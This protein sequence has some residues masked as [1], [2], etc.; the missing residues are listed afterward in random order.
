MYLFLDRGE[1]REKE[2][3][4]NINVWLPLT[5]SPYEDLDCNPGMCPDWESNW[6]PF[7]LQASAESAE[8]HH[9]GLSWQFWGQKPG[10]I[11]L[12]PLLRHLTG[13]NPA[14]KVTLRKDLLTI[15]LRLSATF[16]FFYV[17][18][19]LNSPC[20]SWLS[21]EAALSSWKPP[22]FLPAESPHLTSLQ[23]QH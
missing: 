20:P 6:W 11:Q 8:T 21:T 3:E 12:G 1:G 19:N 14:Y 2:Q 15:S 22:E 9:P 23:N 7:G 17:A 16:T 5:H 4:R 18:V 10:Q 13:C